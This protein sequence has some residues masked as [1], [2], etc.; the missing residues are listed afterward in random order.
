MNTAIYI[1][2]VTECFDLATVPYATKVESDYGSYTEEDNAETLRITV[3]KENADAL[4]TWLAESRD[5]LE[6]RR[7]KPKRRVHPT[8]DLGGIG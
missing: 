4:A 8:A 1:A 2:I 6:L 7:G 3:D 5:V